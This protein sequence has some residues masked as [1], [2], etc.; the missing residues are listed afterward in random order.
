MTK[1]VSL[2]RIFTLVNKKNEFVIA[3]RDGGNKWFDVRVV[4]Y[5]KRD[6][7]LVVCLTEVDR[8]DKGRVVKGEHG[9]KQYRFEV[10]DRGVR[11]FHFRDGSV[12]SHKGQNVFMGN[13]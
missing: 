6:G 7:E 4:C 13:H 12:P 3:T 10:I 9:L 11:D 5:D 2:D 1:S 8:P